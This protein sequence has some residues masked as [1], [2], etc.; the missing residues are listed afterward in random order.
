MPGLCSTLTSPIEL[1]ALPT[2]EEEAGGAGGLFGDD[3]D[4]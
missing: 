3:D 4:W 1:C 2:E